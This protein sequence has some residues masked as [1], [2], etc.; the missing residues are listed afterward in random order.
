MFSLPIFVGLDY[1]QKVIQVCVMDQTRKI[2]ANQSVENDP[3]AV[4]R[5]VAPFSGNVHAAIDTDSSNNASKSNCE[6]ASFCEIIA[7]SDA[8]RFVLA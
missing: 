2:L 5:V 6:F 1:H 7:S 8:L 3:A 4:L